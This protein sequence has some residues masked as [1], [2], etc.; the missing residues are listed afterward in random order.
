MTASELA[1]A[2]RHARTWIAALFTDVEAAPCAAPARTVCETLLGAWLCDTL[3]GDDDGS[4]LL[5]ELA[6]R[7]AI[8]LRDGADPDGCPAAAPTLR[9][10]AAILLRRCGQVVPYLDD[11]LQITAELLAREDR[12]R[13]A[14]ALM[15]KQILLHGVGLCDEPPALDALP[16]LLRTLALPAEPE[17]VER[18]LLHVEAAT[19]WGTREPSGPAAEGWLV[20]LLHGLAVHSLRAYDLPTGCKLLRALCHLGAADAQHDLADFL[21]LQQ[22]PEGCFGFFAPEELELL[23]SSPDTKVD[24]ELSLPVTLQC[25]WALLESAHGWRLFAGLPPRR[26]WEALLGASTHQRARSP[27]LPRSPASLTK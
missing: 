7:A 11:Y 5:T 18:L 14:P 2:T 9:L 4:P 24:W 8:L 6:P 23:R 27:Q 19:G 25:L 10:I 22:R 21:L 15:E 26:T 12:A 17:L 13:P 20:E 16:Q 1:I 3:S